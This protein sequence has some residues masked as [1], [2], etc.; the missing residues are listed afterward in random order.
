MNNNKTNSE[1]QTAT[2]FTVYVIWCRPTNKFYVGVTSQKPYTR[3]RQ[4]K[5][6]KRQLLD[7]EMPPP[8]K[9]RHN[10]STELVYRDCRRPTT[11]FGG[12]RE[13]SSQARE[14]PRRKPWQSR[15]R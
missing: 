15:C 14:V 1:C 8:L 7:K 12:L 13:E 5:R 9:Q 6:G 10:T 4:H 3:I 11:P 2:L